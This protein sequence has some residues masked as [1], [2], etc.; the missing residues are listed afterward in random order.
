LQCY[1]SSDRKTHDSNNLYWLQYPLSL[2]FL[3]SLTQ[4]PGFTTLI[5]CASTTCAI[6]KGCGNLLWKQWF[7]TYYCFIQQLCGYSYKMTHLTYE[8]KQIQTRVINFEATRLE[9]SRRKFPS[10]FFIQNHVK[11]LHNIATLLLMRVLNDVIEYKHTHVNAK[12]SYRCKSGVSFSLDKVILRQE[13][14]SYDNCQ[15]QQTY[16]ICYPKRWVWQEINF[17]TV[18]I[19]F[20]T[21]GYHSLHYFM[22]NCQKINYERFMSI[23]NVNSK[24]A[25]KCQYV[26]RVLCRRKLRFVTCTANLMKIIFFLS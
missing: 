1:K 4:Y 8:S 14:S 13:R 11:N 26:S 10:S 9:I 21:S 12:C 18:D 23:M 24:L 20:K 19:P 3:L 16:N 22:L 17:V 5:H 2:L 25:P 6:S 15:I 7:P